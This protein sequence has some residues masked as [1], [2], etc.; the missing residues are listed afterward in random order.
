MPVPRVC[1]TQQ[2]KRCDLPG[3]T[4]LVTSGQWD[5]NAHKATTGVSLFLPDGN[6]PKERGRF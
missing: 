2:G 4:R 1:L 5:L 3:V 6:S